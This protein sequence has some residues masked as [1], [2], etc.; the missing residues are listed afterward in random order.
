M[1]LGMVRLTRCGRRSRMGLRNGQ[2]NRLIYQCRCDGGRKIY[3]DRM[4]EGSQVGPFCCGVFG[5][6]FSC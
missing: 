1:G 3:L 2:V 5:K 4:G 6:C